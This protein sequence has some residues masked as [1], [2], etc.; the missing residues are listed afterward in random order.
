METLQVVNFDPAKVRAHP[1]V[2]EWMAQYDGKIP[3]ELEEHTPMI[4]DE[5]EE[6]TPMWPETDVDE[7]LELWHDLL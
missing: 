2:I 4:P 7:E 1:R 3:D 5:S 6:H